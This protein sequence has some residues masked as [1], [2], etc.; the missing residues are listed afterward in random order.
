MP[1]VTRARPCATE[2]ADILRAS[3]MAVIVYIL[4]SGTFYLPI[5][6][7][8]LILIE[9][10]L[11]SDPL[12]AYTRFSKSAQ[13]FCTALASMAHRGVYTKNSE[14]VE[15]SSDLSVAAVVSPR[16]GFYFGCVANC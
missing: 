5:G 6:I 12:K 3:T 4:S 13:T 10:Q 1:A 2:I 8:V 14:G 11:M 9:S 16:A 15:K 7:E